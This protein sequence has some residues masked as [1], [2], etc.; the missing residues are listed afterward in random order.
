MSDEQQTPTTP[1]TISPKK[2]SAVIRSAIAD[3]EKKLAVARA[4]NRDR[5]LKWANGEGGNR[6]RLSILV[7]E[8]AT[9]GRCVIRVP[10]EDHAN[11]ATEHGLEGWRDDMG[12]WWAKWS[13]L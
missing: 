1:L 11:V 7:E 9:D 6:S 4:R 3:G 12:Q 2:L 10:D 5:A 8:A 13:P